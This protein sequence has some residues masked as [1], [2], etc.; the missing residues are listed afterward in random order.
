MAVEVGQPTLTSYDFDISYVNP[1][2]PDVLIVDTVSA[3]W[4]VVEIEGDDTGLPVGP[5]Q[6]VSFFDGFGSVDVFKSG[7][8]QASKSSTKSIGRHL[9]MARRALW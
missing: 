1:G 5:N 4:K 3:E 9:P 7:K 8:G 2:G 6:V